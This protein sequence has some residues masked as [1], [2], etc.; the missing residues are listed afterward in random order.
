MKVNKFRHSLTNNLK[1]KF[2]LVKQIYGQVFGSRNDQVR[3]VEMSLIVPYGLIHVKHRF[4]LFIYRGD[5]G[6]KA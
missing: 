1:N 2:K 5:I 3:E 4:N 6:R